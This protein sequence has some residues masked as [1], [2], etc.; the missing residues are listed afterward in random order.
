MNTRTKIALSIVGLG[1][2]TQSLAQITFYEQEGFEGRSFTTQGGVRN[3]DRVG[4][5]DGASSVVVR[6]QRWE[7]CEDIRFNGRCVILRPGQ[8]PSLA[9]M[10]MNDGVFSV[11]VVNSSA[12]FN[13]DRYGPPPPV[14]YDYRQRDNERLF[15]AQVIS[16][17]AVVSS[18]SQQRCWVDREQVVQQDR[19]PLNAGGA[20]IGAV[21]GG[22]LGHQVGGSGRDAATAIGA[23]GGAVVG[24][25]IGRDGGGQQVVTQDVQRCESVPNQRPDYYDVTYNFRGQDYR[26]QM[27]SPPGPSVTV[28]QRGEPR[29]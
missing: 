6:S 15:Q 12:R 24:S 11:R 8:Y 27:T 14:A 9:A 16:V 7:V 23:V 18:P 17:R 3:F 13:D 5:N 2:V 19:N 22:I 1:F 26:V 25:N 4:F 21:I 20:V 29:V 10:G 28:N